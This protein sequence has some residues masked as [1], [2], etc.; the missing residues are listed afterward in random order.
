MPMSCKNQALEISKS[1][2]MIVTIVLHE[3]QLK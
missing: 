3:I 2:E 1:P